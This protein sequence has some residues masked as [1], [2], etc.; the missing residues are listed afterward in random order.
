MSDRQTRLQT[1]LRR[2]RGFGS[3][4]N[5]THHWWM[6]RVTSIAL[7]PLTLWFA[8][9]I[10]ARAGDRWEVMAEWIARPFN[11]VLLIVLI[12]VGFYHTASGLQVVVEDYIRPDRSVMAINMAIK[13]VLTLLGLLAALSVIRLAV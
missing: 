10:A 2:V 8:F 5:G 13:A 12:A 3:A 1:P 11:A 4:K 9:S 7:L 6:Q